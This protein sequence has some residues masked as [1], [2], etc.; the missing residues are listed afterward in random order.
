MKGLTQWLLRITVVCLWVSV[1]VAGTPTVTVYFD[2]AMTA[3]SV[4]QL[5]PGEHTLYV[6]AEGF[7]AHL[8][9][10]EYKIVY[11]PGMKW[12][13]DDA[14]S[15]LKIGETTEGIAQAWPTP[16]DAR[17]SVVVAKAL[18]SW[19]PQDDSV[20]EL[21]VVPNPISGFVRAVAAPDNRVVEAQGQ[22]SLIG[23]GDGPVSPGKLPVLYGA[24]P[25]P[26]KPFTQITYFIPKS[27]H[28]RLGV[29]DVAGRLIATLVDEVRERGEH[30][31]QW[32]AQDLPS[33]VYFCRLE[34]GGY[35]ESKKMMLL[36]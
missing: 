23:E 17:S 5:S 22:T 6:V 36:K 3:K 11:P 30:T 28:V 4:D 33:G 35:T 32:R 16:V 25:N 27:E 12:I 8:V 31:E 9:A 24:N 19:E 21:R 14:V 26:F 7:D 20:C 34:V 13:G 15:P 18:V 10:L 29:Y 1:S 2:E